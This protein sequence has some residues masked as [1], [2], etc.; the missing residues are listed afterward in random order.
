MSKDIIAETEELLGEEKENSIKELD[1]KISKLKETKVVQPAGVSKEPNYRALAQRDDVYR[2]TNKGNTHLIIDWDMV[3]LPP[4]IIGKVKQYLSVKYVQFNLTHVANSKN[5]MTAI[6]H[7]GKTV[8][9]LKQF[10]KERGIPTMIPSMVGVEVIIESKF[11]IPVGESV[12][13]R[14]SQLESLRRYQKIKKK[15]A[16]T[17]KEEGVTDWL[18]FLVFTKVKKLADL[19]KSKRSIATEE[20]L[21]GSHVSLP[22]LAPQGIKDFDTIVASE[23]D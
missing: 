23:E 1:E 18:G 5:V 11:V 12:L 2:V 14:E 9:F 4:D 7:E 21:M 15:I 17:D 22:E 3:L 8:D 10:T 19:K 6:F 20:D 16:H 13:M